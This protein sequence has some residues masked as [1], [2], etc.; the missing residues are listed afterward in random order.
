MKVYGARTEFKYDYRS[1]RGRDAIDNA[2]KEYRAAVKEE[3]HG[4]GFNGPLTGKTIKFGVADG[5]ATYMY[6]DD[7]RR[8]CLI[9]LNEFDGYSYQHIEFLPKKEILA[10]IEREEKRKAF[11]ASQRNGS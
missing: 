11:W 3:L 1:D 4:L 8:S 5:Y 6:A 7:G 2:V 10:E 9:H